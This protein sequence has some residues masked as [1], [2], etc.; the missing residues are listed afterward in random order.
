ML[1]FQSLSTR[2]P[3]LSILL[4]GQGEPPLL[5]STV[6]AYVPLISAFFLR[7][8]VPL[9]RPSAKTAPLILI[10]DFLNQRVEPPLQSLAVNTPPLTQISTL[11]LAVHT[12]LPQLSYLPLHQGVPPLWH[13]AMRH[14][15]L[16]SISLQGIVIPPL[17]PSSVSACDPLLW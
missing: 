5:Q 15:P 13:L 17:L 10:S 6:R 2:T 16:I 3:P 11:P 9:R 8:V 14:P 7:Q 12:P 1:P 4:Q